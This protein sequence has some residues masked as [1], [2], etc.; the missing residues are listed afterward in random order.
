MVEDFL[1]L[2][3]GNYSKDILLNYY[4]IV[5]MPLNYQLCQDSLINYQKM[6]IYSQGQQKDKIDLKNFSIRKNKKN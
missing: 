3:Y 1:V 2:N 5:N 4:I 6:S